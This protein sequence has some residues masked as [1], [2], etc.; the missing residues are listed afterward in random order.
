MKTFT[1][2]VKGPIVHGDKVTYKFKGKTFTGVVKGINPKDFNEIL[3]DPGDGVLDT[4]KIKD[5]MKRY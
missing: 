1:E 4:I 5:V 2:M 3:V